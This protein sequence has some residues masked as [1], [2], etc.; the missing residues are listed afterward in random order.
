MLLD[1]GKLHV[2]NAD[3]PKFLH[4]YVK[5]LNSG[6][7][8]ALVEKLGKNCQMR[9][10]L[11]I[12]KISEGQSYQNI[13][14]VASKIV[15]KP[16]VIFRCTQTRNIHAVFNK[17]VNLD[18]AESLVNEIVRS[19]DPSESHCIDKGVYRT[20][21]RMVGSKKYDRGTRSFVER[22]YVPLGHFAHDIITMDMLKPSIV[23]IKTIN[24]EL[25]NVV[26]K[27]CNTDDDALLEVLGKIHPEYA[28]SKIL[29]YKSFGEN[30]TIRV[31]SKFCTNLGSRH[32]S[33]N[34][35]FV[36]NKSRKLYQ[37]CFCSCLKSRGRI[38]GYCNTY[39]SKAVTVPIRVC[40]NLW[41]AISP[42]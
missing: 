19:V 21:I 4:A 14:D 2:E 39:K 28:A 22:W 35:Y 10:F 7:D 17:A 25:E 9:F 34:V 20:G 11:D 6:D 27:V 36:L 8:I 23:R 37:K 38:H 30:I 32:N 3:L 41:S 16:A 33:C 42:M 31:D 5:C 24:A 15:G 12:D 1:G 40:A 13:I 18:T 29:G 26:C